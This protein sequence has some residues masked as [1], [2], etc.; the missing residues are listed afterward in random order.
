MPRGQHLHLRPPETMQAGCRAETNQPAQGPASHPTV[1]PQGNY[2]HNTPA[3]GGGALPSI[4]SRNGRTSPQPAREVGR[5]HSK[6]GSCPGLSGQRP[7]SH[8]QA[9]AQEPWP[10]SSR[11]TTGVLFEPDLS[12]IFQCDFLSRPALWRFSANSQEPGIRNQ[13]HR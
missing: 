12:T 2:Q 5:P 13:V 8:P 3:M 7:L 9:G 6:C 11:Y 10:H 1:H 4:S